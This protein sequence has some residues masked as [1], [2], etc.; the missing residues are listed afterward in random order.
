MA[1]TPEVKVKKQIRKILDEMG[2]YYAMPIGAGFGNAGVPDF[3]ICLRGRFVAIEC[4][5]EGGK[6]TKLQA[7]HLERIREAGG[8]AVVID[9]TN[10]ED[11]D[12]YLTFK[13]ET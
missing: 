1:S 8:V 6:P 5:A 2:A 9:E 3:L 10:Y 7:Q 13:E 4:K 11:L 12:G